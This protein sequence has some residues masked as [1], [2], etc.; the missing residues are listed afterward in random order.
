MP[1]ETTP[2]A[3]GAPKI[4]LKLRAAAMLQPALPVIVCLWMLGVTIL[5]LRNLVGWLGVNRLQHKSLTT[6]GGDCHA[7]LTRLCTALKVTR[8]VKLVRSTLVAVPTVIGWL[9][10]IILLPASALTGLDTLQLQA[11]LAHELAHIRRCDYLVN[12]IQTIIETLGFHHPAVWWISATIRRER[13]NCCDDI[14]LSVCG[15]RLQY[16]RTLASLE[17]MRQPQA[18]LAVAASGSNLFARI[19]RIITKDAS[20]K[21]RPAWAP[22]AAIIILTTA[23]VLPAVLALAEHVKKKS[24]HPIETMLLDGFRANRAKFQCGKL[25]WTQTTEDEGLIR[26]TNLMQYS[27]SYQLFWDGKKITTRFKKEQVY[28]GD[29][30]NDGQDIYWIETVR[31]GR[32]YDGGLLSRKPKFEYWENFFGVIQWTGVFPMD[33]D[34]EQLKTLK[35][36]EMK[37]EIIGAGP[38]KQIK[39]STRNLK[40]GASGVR[41]FDLAKGCNEVLKEWYNSQGIVYPLIAYRKDAI[42]TDLPF[43]CAGSH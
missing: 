16:A 14:A 4:P 40:D 19:R 39:L 27:G 37:W 18:R 11:I 30:N 7:R 23:L 31:G 42:L 25:T 43:G 9:K 10:P 22:T 15:D 13:E 21:S 28:R 26:K 12:I 34:I 32:T 6:V 1:T 29:P 41:R 36:C 8:P 3:S 20:P 2:K 35:H 5:S 17:E 33:K 38:D 24:A